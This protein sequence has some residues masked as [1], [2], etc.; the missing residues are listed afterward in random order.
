MGW[1]PIALALAG[2]LFFVVLVNYN[3]IK[4][5]KEAVKNAFFN[6]TQTAKARQTLLKVIN[7][8]Q[9]NCSPDN[10]ESSFNFK[11]FEEYRECI[12]LEKKSVDD[13]RA[14]LQVNRPAESDTR[15]VLK[16]LQVLNHRQHI[17]ISVLNRKIREY[18]N[19]ISS[20]PAKMVAQA[21]GFKML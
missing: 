13:S 14:Y 8:P 20:Y 15:K 10:L 11:K 5:H 17:N 2:F 16:S 19:L 1:L 21:T 4:S 9:E 3:S 12:Q 6:F 7:A 18:N